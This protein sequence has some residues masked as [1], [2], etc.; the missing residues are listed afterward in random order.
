LLE[1]DEAR[2]TLTP[3]GAADDEAVD[4]EATGPAVSVS[5]EAESEAEDERSVVDVVG[6]TGCEKSRVMVVVGVATAAVDEEGDVT[7]TPGGGGKVCCRPEAE[8]D[9]VDDAVCAPPDRPAPAAAA[10]PSA[11][12]TRGGGMLDVDP[13]GVLRRGW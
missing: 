7:W 4:D 10:A 9:G 2:L 6:V 8:E 5:V 13:P 3:E 1:S 11:A 12:R